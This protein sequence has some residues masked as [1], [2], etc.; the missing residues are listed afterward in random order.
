MGPND[1]NQSSGLELDRPARGA[2]NTSG[3]DLRSVSN[4][5]LQGVRSAQRAQCQVLLTEDMAAG[6]PVEGIEIV[7][8][9]E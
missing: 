2:P 8:P 4:P 1:P 3:S 7:N 6:T 5:S 9:F